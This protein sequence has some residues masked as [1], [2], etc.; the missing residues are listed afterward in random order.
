MDIYNLLI[1]L[2]MSIIAFWLF[3]R[4]MTKNKRSIDMFKIQVIG[5]IQRKVALSYLECLDTSE[6]LHLIFGL[7]NSFSIPIPVAKYQLV[8]TQRLLLPKYLSVG[9]R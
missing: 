3:V 8:Q 2:L 9:I 5:K 4:E 7:A 1:G 6:I